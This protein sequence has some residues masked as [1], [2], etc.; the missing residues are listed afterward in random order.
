ML[1]CA[2]AQ[3]R[4]IRCADEQE[5]S[6]T[7]KYVCRSIIVRSDT[8]PA[9]DRCKL[10]RRR[11]PHDPNEARFRHRRTRLVRV[12]NKL[13]ESTPWLWENGCRSRT[14]AVSLLA[15]FLIGLLTSFFNR[16]SL[17]F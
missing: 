9:R 1:V 13:A 14:P 2:G 17:V 4:N 8:R 16:R 7:T 12:F 3:A 6:N 10:D 11:S 5:L 15:L